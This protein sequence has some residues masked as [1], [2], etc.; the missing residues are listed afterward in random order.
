LAPVRS[1]STSAASSPS[2]ASTRWS[3]SELCSPTRATCSRERSTASWSV[4]SASRSA[5]VRIRLA[6]SSASRS[7]A[8]ALCSAAST[9]DRTC[10][11]AAWAERGAAAALRG[12]LQRLELVGELSQ[13]LVDRLGLVAAAADGEVLLLDGLTVE[14]H[15]AQANA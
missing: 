3:M 8:W 13:V 1:D 11:D 7:M 4:R 14:G 5:S 6:C 10:S 15:W 12:A 9:I 2:I